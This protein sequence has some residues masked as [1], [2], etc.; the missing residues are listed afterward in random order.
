VPARADKLFDD[1]T[2]DT[3]E[4]LSVLE[5]KYIGS[6]LHRVSELHLHSHPV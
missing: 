3:V 6:N 5:Y 2:I 4:I 1:L